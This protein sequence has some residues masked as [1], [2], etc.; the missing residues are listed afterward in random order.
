MRYFL[1]FPDFKWKALTLSYD[2]GVQADKRLI[3]ILNKHGIKATFN[4]NTGLAGQGDRIP[5]SEWKE[6]YAGHELAVHGQKHLS[7]I[8]VPTAIALNDV[9]EDRKSLEKLLEKPVTG[10]AYA[11]GTFN[12]EVVQMLKECGIDYSRTVISTGRF[13]V[14]KDWLR[15]PATCHHNDTRLN[16]LAKTFAELSANGPYWRNHPKLFYLWGHSYEFNN[17]DNWEVIEEFAKYV[18]GR[19]EIWYATNG[20]IYDYIE[21]FDRLVFSAQGDRVYNPT[22]TVL[23]MD[24]FGKQYVVAPGESIELKK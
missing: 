11:Y 24:Y 20:E 9:L 13:D 10:M 5:M 3:A 21:A 14:P 16:E 23:Y 2:D 4:V 19:E 8:D 22:C 18:G 1:R 7:L 6:L 17:Q 12:D 15:L